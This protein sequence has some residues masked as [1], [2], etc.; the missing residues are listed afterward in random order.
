M[1]KQATHFPSLR[2]PEA[3]AEATSPA[4]DGQTRTP[5]AEPAVCCGGTVAGG[6][7]A[8]ALD[9]GACPS[10]A[11]LSAGGAVRADPCRLFSQRAGTGYRPCVCVVSAAARW[12]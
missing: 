6:H 11:N 3:P 1:V 8:G 12:R 7:D 5:E 10:E 9:P 2:Q 4:Q